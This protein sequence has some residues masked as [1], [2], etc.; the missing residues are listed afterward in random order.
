MQLWQ[1]DNRIILKRCDRCPCEFY[2]VGRCDCHYTPA[3]A[4]AIEV[5]SAKDLFS[6]CQG[7]NLLMIFAGPFCNKK[8][9]EKYKAEH[10]GE[11]F[12]RLQ[13]NEY[14]P[15]DW[16]IECFAQARSDWNCEMT[17][18]TAIPRAVHISQ[19][20]HGPVCYRVPGSIFF[21]S[22]KLDYPLF[23]SDHEA[24]IFIMANRESLQ[25][26]CMGFAVPP[27]TQTAAISS[28]TFAVP[29]QVLDIYNELNEE[30][31]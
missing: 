25:T 22:G 13:T 9:A 21:S 18:K 14:C 19:G 24:V 28:S 29:S 31:H 5:I 27:E 1:C 23:K 7:N 3:Q 8:L 10:E 17:V 20:N 6:G 12:T 26:F 30:L 11:F 15:G 16:C 2:V 4:E